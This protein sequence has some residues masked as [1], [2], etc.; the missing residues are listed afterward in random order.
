V[1]IC[2]HGGRKYYWIRH[3][4]S[5]SIRPRSEA[6]AEAGKERNTNP[7]SYADSGFEVLKSCSFTSKGG[8][9]YYSRIKPYVCVPNLDTL[10]LEIAYQVGSAHM[11][12]E[13]VPAIYVDLLCMREVTII[14][15]Y[16]DGHSDIDVP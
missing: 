5:F 10:S 8:Q 3:D 15:S 6:G 2:S 16:F 4:A 9:S 11:K 14:K 1:W 13:P 12:S 7:P